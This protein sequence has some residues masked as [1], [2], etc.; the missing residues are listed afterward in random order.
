MIKAH[1][2]GERTEI[3]I[4]GTLITLVSELTSILRSLRNDFTQTFDETFAD[5]VIANAGRMAFAKTDEE[6]DEVERE[7]N[8]IIARLAARN[9]EKVASDLFEN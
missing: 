7:L 8:D 9:V 1:D 5:E 2:N 4:H 6:E 3:K